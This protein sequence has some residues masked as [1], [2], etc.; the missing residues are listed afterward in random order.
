VSRLSRVAAF[1]LGCLCLSGPA[2]AASP[3]YVEGSVGAQ[4]TEDRTYGGTYPILPGETLQV[5]NTSSFS[6]GALFALG[7]GYRLP[8]RLRVEGELG[9][10]PFSLTSA[11]PRAGGLAAT[12]FDGSRRTITSGGARSL[13]TATAGLF[14]DLP[15][16]GR[17]V[18]YLGGGAGYYNLEAPVGYFTDHG[19]TVPV[20]GS[21]I[22]SAL[23]FAETGL[24]IALGGRWTA[25]PSYRF[26]YL[27]VPGFSGFEEHVLK[28]G[29]RYAL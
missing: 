8:H 19:L 14:Y 22:N 5:T 17:V 3:W 15:V 11:A 24:G 7:V 26:Q 18:P 1:S 20:P 4:W 21:S 10:S 27:I 25:V 2:G 23:V 9:Y 16:A 28:L 6:P 29:L 12:L 13:F